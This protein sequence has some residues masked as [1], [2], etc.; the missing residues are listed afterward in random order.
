MVAL[1]R[2]MAAIHPMSAGV[3]GTARRAVMAVCPSLLTRP[4]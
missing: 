2:V 3:G 4:S 1:V